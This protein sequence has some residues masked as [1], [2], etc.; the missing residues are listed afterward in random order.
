[1]KILSLFTLMSKP[2]WLFFC[3]LLYLYGVFLFVF[4][5][6]VLFE[7]SIIH[8]NFIEKGDYYVVETRCLHKNNNTSN[9]STMGDF[10]CVCVFVFCCFLFFLSL[11]IFQNDIFWE[12]KNAECFLWWLGLVEGLGNRIYNLY[13]IKIIMSMENVPIKHRNPTC[14]TVTLNNTCFLVGVRSDIVYN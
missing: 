9:F 2:I 1:M 5:V 7:S 14:V 6:V 8:C 3:I 12:C 10:L 13:F 11:Q 4:F